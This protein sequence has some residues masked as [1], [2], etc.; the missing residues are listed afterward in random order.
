MRGFATS[1][2]VSL[3][4][5][6][7]QATAIAG[8]FSQITLHDDNANAA[9]KLPIY[10]SVYSQGIFSANPDGT[11]QKLI[12]AG[13]ALS[14]LEIAFNG[15]R[16]CY[17][18]GNASTAYSVPLTGGAPST[19]ISNVSSFTV[20]PNGKRIAYVRYNNGFKIYVANTDLTGEVYIATAGNHFPRVAF[21]SDTKI[22]YDNYTAIYRANVDG[23]GITL[24][25]DQVGTRS[26]LKCSPDGRYI[27]WLRLNSNSRY[28]CN[29]AA[30]RTDGGM[31]NLVEYDQARDLKSV[32][33]SPDGQ[34]ILT[35]SANG[36]YQAPVAFPAS[37]SFLFGGTSVPTILGATHGY[38]PTNRQLV[39]NAGPFG[40]RASAIIYTLSDVGAANVSSFLAFDAT[41]PSSLVVNPGDNIP[42][43]R[44][45]NF[46][47]ECDKLTALGYSLDRSWST[48]NLIT[49]PSNV[50]GA[51]VTLD[52]K[53]GSVASVV[54]YQVSRSSHP[55]ITHVG[56]H[57]V[58]K[59]D[60]VST[61]DRH[62]VDH[63][64]Q[65]RVELP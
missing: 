41:T 32:T 19:L 30:I 21:L 11:Q 38:N 25:Y 3:S 29:V 40:T 39:G 6:T 9:G 64:P 52:G 60:F 17:L 35:S 58:I 36:V 55:V 13:A 7:I 43:S 20:S 50:N 45:V 2:P 54:T 15:T 44:Y 10:Y 37:A 47:V 18:D 5:A 27:S 46:D 23:T 65:S 48:A 4:T 14:N 33:F 53:D 28:V 51:L 49:G 24:T 8:N 12:A 61:Y 22:Y 26:S 34:S 59:G 31:T 1:A 56:D 16:L 57:Q 63:G 42:G 62:G